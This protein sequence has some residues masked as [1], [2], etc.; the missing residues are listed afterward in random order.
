MFPPNPVAVLPTTILREPATFVAAAPVSIEI[1]PVST[2]PAPVAT[3]IV[4]VLASLSDVDIVTAPLLADSEEPLARVTLP[5]VMLVLVPALS[6]N[7]P[8]NVAD[9]PTSNLI[10]PADA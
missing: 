3:E 4:P 2:K 1:D 6:S 7:V 10:S 8:P 9:A 5:P